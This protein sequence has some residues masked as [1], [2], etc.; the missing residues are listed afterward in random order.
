MTY[1]C[2]LLDHDGVVVSTLDRAYRE[3]LF[4]EFA[5][6]V[7]DEH[8]LETPPESLVTELNEGLSSDRVRVLG[9]THGY[10]PATL[11]QAR[12]EAMKRTLLQA[13]TARR[14][15][16]YADIE[17]LETIS[18]P[19]GI[20]SNNQRRVIEAILRDHDAL[21]LFETIRARD[22]SLE[23]LD[24]KKPT[25]TLLERAIDDLNVS[26]P[27]FVGDRESDIVAANR[28]DVDIAFLRR[29]HNA[30]VELTVEPTYERKTLEDVVELLS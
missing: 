11:W 6:E 17:A 18:M 15:Y 4:R 14:K 10:E 9:A 22:P 19:R 5:I 8:G 24:C 1:D 7:F 26:D 16:P 28:A 12:D 3:Q 23:S 13:A 2:L 25:P 29:D 20:V 21:E 30:S 27:L